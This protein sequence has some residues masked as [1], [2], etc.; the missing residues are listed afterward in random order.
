MC[1][2]TFLLMMCESMVAGLTRNPLVCAIFGA[3]GAFLF[4]Q[5][6]GGLAQPVS[7]LV[8]TLTA[9]GVLHLWRLSRSQP[10]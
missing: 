5:I 4:V 6:S 2:L 9:I 7:S 1:G 8:F 10:G 3:Y